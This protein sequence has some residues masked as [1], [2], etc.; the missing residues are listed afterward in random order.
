ME[1]FHKKPYVHIFSQNLLI[2]PKLHDHVSV[3]RGL[4]EVTKIRR[5]KNEKKTSPVSST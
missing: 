2:N 4:V 3:K 1:T 5:I